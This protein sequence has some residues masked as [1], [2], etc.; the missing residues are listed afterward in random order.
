[1]AFH[2]IFLFPGDTVINYHKLGALKPQ[3]IHFF[4][5]VLETVSTKTVSLDKSKVSEEL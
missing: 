3:D 1:M 4:S 2:C 5:T